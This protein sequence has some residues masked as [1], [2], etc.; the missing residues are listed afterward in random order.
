MSI[1]VEVAQ[2]AN[3]SVEGVVRVLTREPVSDAIKEQ[4]LAVLDDLTAAQT[5]VLQRF[6]LAAL[7]DELP[8]PGATN[9]VDDEPAAAA[10]APHALLGPG[11]PAAEQLAVSRPEAATLEP[12][13]SVLA[14]LAEAIRD[15]R[16]ETDAE[17][18]ERVDDLAVVIDL[19]SSGWQGIENR[20]GRIERKLEQLET[21]PRPGPTPRVLTQPAP[22]AAAPPPP[23]PRTPATP[24]EESAEPDADSKKSRLL[25]LA[26]AVGVI[27]AIA[28]TF[29]LID[30]FAGRSDAPRLAAVTTTAEDATTTDTREASSTTSARPTTSE[31]LGTS[32]TEPSAPAAST[33]QPARHW[34]WA[35][36]DAADYYAVEFLR[37]GERLYRAITEETRLSLPDS[38]VFRP[39]S[40]RW[41]VRPGY[42]ARGARPLGPPVVDSSFT[43]S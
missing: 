35:P 4:V 24:A 10:D 5:R 31:V 16:R 8:R 42:G 36:V 28:V 15:L 19:I 33:F 43:V 3:V 21:A 32:A 14:E 37:N 20:L 6:A 39:G 34:S 17:R 12:L 7:H 30:V 2:K 26:T 18:R 40:Y 11:E 22:A 1:L 27:G 41:T 25:S 13:G 29:V 38:V 23:P 9:A